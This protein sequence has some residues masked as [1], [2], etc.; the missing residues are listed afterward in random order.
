M[1]KNK[2]TA[3]LL[4]LS[5]LTASFTGCQ[6]ETKP[7]SKSGVLLNTSVT[8][9]I[10][11]SN[12]TKLSDEA[13]EMINKYDSM[14]SR[15]NKDS[16]IYKL[17]EAGKAT[18]SDD[19]IE[20]IKLGLQYSESSKGALDISVEPITALWNFTSENPKVPDKEKLQSALSHVN[21]KNITINGNEVTLNDTEGGIDLGAIAKGYIGGKV[22]SFLRSKGVKSAVLSLGGNIVCIGSKPDGKSFTVG[23]QDPFEDRNVYSEKVSV[24]NK[25]VVTSG[26][27]ERYFEENGKKYH[28]ILDTKTGYPYENGIVAVSII[29][30]D[31]I[32]SDALSTVVFT[33]GIQEG[34]NYINEINNAECMII[35]NNGTRHYSNNFEKYL[36]K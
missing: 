5:L 3:I 2:F 12:D 24:S 30:D 25:S 23:L 1:K 6:K 31:A 18:L 27:Y 14:F 20:V 7:I 13:F 35:E 32:I 33:L 9:T 34:I 11:D 28:H 19:T 15:T 26:T 36:V 16:E 17:N 8:V 22:E 29:C 21:Y 10:Y 4:S